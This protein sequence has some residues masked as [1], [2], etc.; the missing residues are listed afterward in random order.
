MLR[1]LLFLLVL[2]HIALVP[3]A[4][5]SIMGAAER[6]AEAQS[7][8]LIFGI[9]PFLPAAELHQSFSP[10]LKY[11]E[12]RIGIPIALKITSDHAEGVR[13][14]V[15]AKVDLAFVG[16]TLYVEITRN[17]P[18]VMPL[19]TI[20]GVSPYLRGVV[21]VREDSPLTSIEDLKG[22][23]VAFVAPE[24]TTGFQL[25]LYVFAQA[26]VHLRDL[27]GYSFL[28]NHANVG[29][30]VLA[31]R[32]AAGAM[33]YKVFENLQSR[34][35][36]VLAQLPEVM[37]HTFLATE[38]VE[39]RLAEKVKNILLQMDA[40]PEGAEVLAQLRSDI[41]AIVPVDEAD[42]T[43]LSFYVDYA[44]KILKDSREQY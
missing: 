14:C 20:S 16:P 42:F 21:V 29:Y 26:G 41:T 9:H 23:Q 34:G 1:R 6:S 28:G 27:A 43:A 38:R 30:A 25:P 18:R 12:A 5:A 40:C 4:R 39:S 24:T 33:K 13:L 7:R 3:G 31:G 11:L 15:E 19:G 36:R 35:L 37:N 22:T 2:T 8:G 10:L 44:Q 32:F 17:N